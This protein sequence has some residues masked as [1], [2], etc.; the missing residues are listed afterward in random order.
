MGKAPIATLTL[1]FLQQ[2]AQATS[3]LIILIKE[4]VRKIYERNGRFKKR[5]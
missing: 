1:S 3:R 2:N 5:I 4:Q